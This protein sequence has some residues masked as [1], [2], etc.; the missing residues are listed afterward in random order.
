MHWFFSC[1]ELVRAIQFSINNAISYHQ[2]F[3][4]DL[5]TDNDNGDVDVHEEVLKFGAEVGEKASHLIA[6]IVKRL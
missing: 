6:E 4:S 3:R 5:D 1:N 2:M